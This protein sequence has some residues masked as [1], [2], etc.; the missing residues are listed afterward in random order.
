MHKV[1]FIGGKFLPLHQGHVSA[2]TKA[3]C[4]VEELYVVLSYSDQRDQSLCQSCSF[5][6]IP[7]D[8][9]LKWLHQLTKDMENVKVIAVE[10]EATS[11]ESY[12]WERGAFEIKQKIGK[13]IDM[14][15]SSEDS[16]E[17]I[18]AKLYPESKHILLDPERTLFPISATKIRTKGAFACWEYLPDIVKP[19]FVKKVV[20]VGTESC[21][22]STLVRY[23]GKVFQTSYV[24]EYGR[25][26]CEYLGGCDG[27]LSEVEFQEICY[28]QKIKELE[29]Q[30]QANKLLFVDTEAIVSQYYSHLYL[31]KHLDLIDAI[32]KT[33]HYDLW[34][35]LEPDVNWVDDGYRVYGEEEV[36]NKNNQL[37]KEMLEQY[38]IHYHTITGSYEKRLDTA[39]RL[40]NNLLMDGSVIR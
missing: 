8:I 34:L 40:V 10:D 35:F 33:Q 14:V 30:R 26:V 39:I 2:I 16:Y 28:Q 5:P 7:S 18:F 23:L 31:G 22:K 3:A 20:V 17:P 13:P 27:I 25:T 36:R 38:G 1:G 37:L 9:R 15:F 12:D 6:Y 19:F 32:I 11:D 21:G 4:M 29:A 24:E